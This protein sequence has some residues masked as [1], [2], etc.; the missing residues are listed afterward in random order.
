MSRTIPTDGPLSPEDRAYLTMRGDEARIKWFDQLYPPVDEAADDEDEA[1]ESAA[2]SEEDDED[3]DDED[4]DEDDDED[5]DYENW[6]IADLKAEIESRNKKA[7]A[8][9][10]MSVT[11]VKA[12]LAARLRENDAANA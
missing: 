5:P 3:E 6:T 9:A 7:G 4:E 2:E 10:Q 8:D 12:D 11:G 1:E